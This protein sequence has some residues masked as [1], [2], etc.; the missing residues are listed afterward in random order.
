MKKWKH[1]GETMGTEDCETSTSLTT[2]LILMFAASKRA[3]C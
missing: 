3:N 2:T 1:E